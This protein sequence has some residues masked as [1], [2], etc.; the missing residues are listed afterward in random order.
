MTPPELHP[1]ISVNGAYDSQASLADDL[2]LCL[3]VGAGLVGVPNYKIDRLGAADAIALLKHSPVGVST[4]CHPDLAALDAPSAWP[5]QLS[6]ARRTV[7]IAVE[8]EAQ[9]VYVTT[10]GRGRSSWRQ[11]ANAFTEVAAELRTYAD[12]LGMPLLV[13]AT[14]P[15][16]AELSI[17]HTLA[18]QLTVCTESGLSLCLDTFASWSDSSFESL[19]DAAAGQCGLVQI[20]DY[21]LGERSARDRAVPG[22]G[23][24]DF[25]RI[26]VA[27]RNANFPGA[28]DVELMGRRLDDE[29]RVRGFRRA[30]MWTSEQLSAYGFPSS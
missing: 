15:F 8:V 5:G 7:Q 13:E 28:F 3:E 12:S 22:D 17:V 4:V 10:G 25:A 29:G 18:D 6:A 11:A 23:V 20:A 16:Y 1:L 27:L 21:A 19:L 24:I 14:A 30:V 2:D 26:F 9:S